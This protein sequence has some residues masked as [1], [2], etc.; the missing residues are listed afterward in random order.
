MNLSYTACPYKVAAF[1]VGSAADAFDVEYSVSCLG[2]I[3]EKAEARC[4]GFQSVDW[5]RRTFNLELNNLIKY[6]D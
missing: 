2:I 5:G 6:P 1:G 3:T 4:K